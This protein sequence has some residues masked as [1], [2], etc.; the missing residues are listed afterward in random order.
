[1]EMVAESAGI[2]GFAGERAS[3]SEPVGGDREVGND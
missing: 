2:D 1:M 3:G